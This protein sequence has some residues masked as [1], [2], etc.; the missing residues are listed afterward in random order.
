[1]PA[2]IAVLICVER[3]FDLLECGDEVRMVEVVSDGDTELIRLTQIPHSG[4]ITSKDWCLARN[5]TDTSKKTASVPSAEIMLLGAVPASERFQLS[6]YE[7]NAAIECSGPVT[8]DHTT[9][10]ST[11]F[12]QIREL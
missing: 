10:L 4:L 2:R 8:T 12:L 7:Q 6:K 5:W 9:V 11:A 3:V 1:M